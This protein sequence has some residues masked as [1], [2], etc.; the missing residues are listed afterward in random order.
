MIF[1]PRFEPTLIFNQLAQATVMMGVPTF[2]VR[3]LQDSR[4]DKVATGHMRLFVCGSAPLLAE[5]HRAWSARTGYDIL[6]R[7]G[8][9]ETGMIASNPY[10]GERLAGTVGFALPG[11]S[12]RITDLELGHELPPD[13]IGMIEVAGPNVF[14]GYW[15]QPEKT[16]EEFHG[17]FFITGDLGCRDT[18]GYL[19][20]V[21]RGKDLIIS[22]GYNVYPKEVESEID[23]LPGVDESAVIGVAHPD[24][25]EGVTALI[26]A[27]RRSADLTA[28][29][30][31]AALRQRLAAYKCPKHVAF[32]TE[33]PRN[34]MG[35][36]QKN[37]LRASYANLYQPS[38]PPGTAR[39]DTPS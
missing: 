25:G 31:Q 8:M 21:G 27:P 16:R 5:T 22:G 19:R 13:Q 2:Y 3:L 36:V 23:A 32:V 12:V 20:I 38:G 34:T 10:D 33:L 37:A 39:K 35:K 28:Q 29:A 1:L 9:T 18:R 24:L 15:D 7:Y 17:P 11:V 6:E 14:A 4:L 30:V 26:V